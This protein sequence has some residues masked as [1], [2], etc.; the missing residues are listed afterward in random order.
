MKTPKELAKEA[1][2][3]GIVSKSNEDL[4]VFFLEETLNDCNNDKRSYCC[5]EKTFIN[6]SDS[7]GDCII[8]G[9]KYRY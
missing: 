9:K 1:V 6:Q 2:D 4:L 3:R 7:N 8:C 5:C